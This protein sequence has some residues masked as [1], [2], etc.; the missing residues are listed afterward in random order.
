[1]TRHR[2]TAG[3][4]DLR[5]LAVATRRSARLFGGIEDGVRGPARPQPRFRLIGKPTPRSVRLVAAAAR[6][7]GT[8]RRRCRGR[9]PVDR[10][11]SPS[12]EALWIGSFATRLRARSRRSF[13]PRWTLAFGPPPKGPRITLADYAKAN[14][15]KSKL[16]PATWRS[17]TRGTTLLT[18]VTLTAAPPVETLYNSEAFPRWTKGRRTRCPSTSPTACGVDAA[19]VTSTGLRS[20]L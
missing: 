11:A 14:E 17:G 16:A 7:F 6:W 12:F 13:T 5:G 9:R 3:W 10:A 8:A 2:S 1:M 19:G 20:A 18:P 15:A 4:P